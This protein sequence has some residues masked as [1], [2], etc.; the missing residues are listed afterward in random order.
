VYQ[1]I[2]S[3]SQQDLEILSFLAKT[4]AIEDERRIA[5]LALHESETRYRNLYES[6]RDA[7]MT[8]EPPSWRFTSGN[9]ATVQMFMARDE[10]EF[11]SREPWTL[12]P[13]RQPDGRESGD[14]AKEMIETA[15]QNGSHFFEWTHKRFN[16]EEFPA[17]VLLSRVEHAE[18]AFIQA[19]VRDITEQK[20][21]DEYIRLLAKMSDDAPVS[22]LI[23]DFDGHILYANEET[24]RLHGFTREEFLKKNLHEIDVPESEHLI[25][26]RIQKIR[27]EG[28]ADFEVEHLRKDGSTFPLHVNGKIVTWNGRK[29]LLSI[30]T[31]LTERKRAEVVLRESEELHRSIFTASPDG[32]A[33]TDGLGV[34]SRVSP[35]V[36]KIFGFAREDEVLGMPLDMFL[37]PEDRDRALANIAQMHQGVFTGPGEYR[38]LRADGSTLDIEANAEF[39]RDVEGHPAGMVILVRDITGR[40]QAEEQL[41]LLLR[42]KEILLHEIH[43]RVRNTIQLAVSMMKMQIR[44]END[45]QVRE[46]L[47]GTQNR[48]NAIAS[49]FDMLY[50]SEDMSRV[51]LRKII[52]S[53]VGF[54]QSAYEPGKHAI[55]SDIRIDITELGVDRALPLALITS[56]LV[57]NAFQNAFP[58]GRSGMVTIT[59]SED[60]KGQII[61]TVS[62][63]GSGLPEGFS[64][65]ES[66]TTGFTLVRTLVQQIDGTLTYE[67]SGKGTNFVITVPRYAESGKLRVSE[68]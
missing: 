67:T 60:V 23:H 21:S 64:L 54:I 68:T 34:V 11:T 7:I 37:I 13:D 62:D 8:I 19:T 57:T 61:L 17:T 41:R 45:N 20:R 35:S 32:I 36:L 29:V 56:E 3:P 5:G 12:S 38:A 14:K 55:Q 47:L 6:S 27:E 65:A 44:R 24:F 66:G 48:L 10:A 49:T 40:K 58:D 22:I 50:Y 16:G 33:I 43:H 63:N 28:A 15:M 53:I 51:N 59:G 9:P 30:A 18:K 46:A 26:E 39:V 31:D 25:G 4:V 42:E 2:Y 52:R 1:N